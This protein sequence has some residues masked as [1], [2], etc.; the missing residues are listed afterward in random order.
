MLM[1]LQREVMVR[2]KLS[3]Q[4]FA[5][6]GTSSG[7]PGDLRYGEHRKRVEMQLGEFIKKNREKIDG[8]IRVKGAKGT[9][10]DEERRQWILNDEGLYNWAKREGVKI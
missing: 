2:K 4:Y 1:D 8:V 10:N 6:C 7:C 5:V 3:E 9:L